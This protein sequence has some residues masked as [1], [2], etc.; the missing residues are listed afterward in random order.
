MTALHTAADT[1]DCAFT[2]HRADVRVYLNVVATPHYVVGGDG[3]IR[4]AT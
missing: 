3:T 4:N 1:I 2:L